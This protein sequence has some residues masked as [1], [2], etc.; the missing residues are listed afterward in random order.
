[1]LQAEATMD[2]GCCDELQFMGRSLDSGKITA[3][4][5]GPVSWAAHGDLAGVAV[6]AL[7]G[8]ERLD[9]LTPPLTLSEAETNFLMR[10]DP[11]RIGCHKPTRRE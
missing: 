5:D 8:E 9:G 4:E 1:V 11:D 6:T 3:R 2:S 7:T 10:R